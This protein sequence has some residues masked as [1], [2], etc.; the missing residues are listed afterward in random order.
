MF[1]ERLEVTI[2]IGPL[3]ELRPHVGAGRT[4]ARM[5]EDRVLGRNVSLNAG[6]NV[7]LELGH[8]FNPQSG[9]QVWCQCLL[10]LKSQAMPLTMLSECAGVSIRL[11]RLKIR[12]L[13]RRSTL[14]LFWNRTPDSSKELV[15][16][17][18]VMPPTRRLLLCSRKGTFS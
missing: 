15:D 3:A 4:P 17:T 16:S 7:G 13:F 2:G 12:M 6:P 9:E 8:L 18:H 1:V 5:Q 11:E 10:D 14:G